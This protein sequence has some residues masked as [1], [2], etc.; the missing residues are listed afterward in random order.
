VHEF[1]VA[2]KEPGRCVVRSNTLDNQIQNSFKL[3]RGIGLQRFERLVG[4]RA[5]KEQNL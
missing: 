2:F 3:E 1:L 5:L 4:R